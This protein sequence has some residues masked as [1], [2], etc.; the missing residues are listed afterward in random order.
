MRQIFINSFR[1]SLS[2]SITQSA[3][4]LTIPADV[5]DGINLADGEYIA[6]TIGRGGLY[7]IVHIINRTENALGISR[8]QEGTTARSWSAG[9]PLAITLTAETAQRFE[10]GESSGGGMLD[11]I[12][13]GSNGEVL[14]TSSGNVLFY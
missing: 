12:L 10:D 8:A 3:A 11:R 4:V 9:T 2:A 14:T 6:A 13:V 7:E 1:T 5:A